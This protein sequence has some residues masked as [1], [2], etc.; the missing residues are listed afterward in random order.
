M[1]AHTRSAEAARRAGNKNSELRKWYVGLRRS[2]FGV[3]RW[4]RRKK[5]CYSHED[6]LYR[7]ARITLYTHRA[8]L[9]LPL[10]GIDGMTET[11]ILRLA[12]IA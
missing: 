9:E 6:E 1:P 8:S 3:E 4:T 11:E 2:V 5:G 12:G 7:N 10:F